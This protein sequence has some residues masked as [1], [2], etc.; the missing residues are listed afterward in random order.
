MDLTNFNSSNILKQ[1][2]TNFSTLISQTQAYR[3]AEVLDIKDQNSINELIKL[4]KA[5]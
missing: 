1:V 4:S 2:S 5:I 3:T